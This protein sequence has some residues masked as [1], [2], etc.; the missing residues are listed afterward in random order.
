MNTPFHI[1]YRPAEIIDGLA[2]R[3]IGLFETDD[4]ADI[5]LQLKAN[6]GAIAL[7]LYADNLDD[8]LVEARELG[9]TH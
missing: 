1:V 8:A 6:P 9:F 7:Q 2:E 4:P 5:T 3:L